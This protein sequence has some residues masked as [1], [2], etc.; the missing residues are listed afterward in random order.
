MSSCENIL[1]L[2]TE[3]FQYIQTHLSWLDIY[4]L[5]LTCRTARASCLSLRMYMQVE[6]RRQLASRAGPEDD[7]EA[8]VKRLEDLLED[9]CS[10]FG[11]FLQAC[12]HRKLWSDMQ[13]IEVFVCKASGPERRVMKSKT[14]T[15]VLR[16]VGGSHCFHLIGNFYLNMY[17]TPTVEC[18]HILA[19]GVCPAARAYVTELDFSFLRCAYQ[20]VRGGCHLWARSF[21]HM[22][23]GSACGMFVIN[24]DT[25]GWNPRCVINFE[26]IMIRAKRTANKR[27][28]KYLDRGFFIAVSGDGTCLDKDCLCGGHYACV[29]NWVKKT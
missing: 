7:V 22:R 3:I 11:E 23:N 16:H 15:F 12:L 21:P 10:L 25:Y 2:P 4:T 17:T 5:G 27:I 28:G 24:S 9:G 29:H 18:P 14:A 19:N 13:E 8:A 20:S 6:I 26:G 1:L